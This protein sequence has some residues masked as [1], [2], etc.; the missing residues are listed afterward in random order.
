NHSLGLKDDG[1]IIA[2]G[3]NNY[4]QC[5]VPLPNSGFTAISAGRY[6]SLGLKE[7]GSLIA[8]GWNDYDQCNIPL[9]N[10]GFTAI[11]AGYYHNL[12]LKEDGSIVAWGANFIGQCDIPLPN[13][14]FIVINAGY[15]H[16][17]GLKA[18]GSLVGWGRCTHGECDIPVP[19]C[20]FT[21]I[22]AGYNLSL[23]IKEIPPPIEVL[24]KFIPQVL[25]LSNAGRLVK[26]HFTLPEEFAVEDVDANTPAVITYFGLESNNLSVLLNDEGL[27]RVE[28][29]FNR[30]DLCNSITSYDQNIE[31]MVIGRFTTGQQFYGTDIIKITDRAFEYLDLFVSYWLETYCIEPDWCGG[32]DLNADS[33]VNFLDFALLERCCIEVPEE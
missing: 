21:E 13:S 24:M 25:N 6:H 11:S 16:N 15:Y 10:T 1:S 19:N 12:G 2:W 31:V 7:D 17:L 9:P 30:S 28:A 32:A 22:A 20:G 18:D 33:L 8:W 4:G 5:D 14:D 29:T 23:A 27:V 3:S 26:V